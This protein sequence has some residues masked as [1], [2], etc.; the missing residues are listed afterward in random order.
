MA[1]FLRKEPCPRCRENGGDTTGDNLVIYNDDSAHCFVC[2]YTIHSEEHKALHAKEDLSYLENAVEFTQEWHEKFKKESTFKGGKY[3]G[4]RD[5]VYKHFG[6]RH[7]YNETTRVMESQWYPNTVEGEISG[8]KKRVLPKTFSAI[9]EV[10]GTA[11]LFGQWRFMN[12]KGKYVVITAGEID[13][14]SAY[15][16]LRDYQISKGNEDYEPIPVV[17]PTTGESGCIKQLQKH[18]EWLN[19]FDKIIV[20]FDNDKAGK[21]ATDKV[22]KVLPKGKVYVMDFAMKDT[23]EMLVAGKEKEWIN[24]FFKAHQYSPAGVIGSDRLYDEL[25]AKAA[26]PKITFPPF[27]KELN[28]ATAGGMSLKQIINVLAGSGIGKTT[29]VNALVKHWIFN[30]PYKVG[31]VSLEADC[32]EYASYLISESIGRKLSLIEDP[33]E[34]KSVLLSEDVRENAES[35]FQHED[36]SPRFYLIDDRGDFGGL[37]DRIEEL[38]ISCNVQL[39]VLDPL[40]DAMAGMAIDEQ[41]LFMSWMKQMIKMYDITFVNINHTRKGASGNEASKGA[42]LTEESIIGSST[43]YKSAHMNITLTRNKHE[44]DEI[45]RN[46]TKITLTKCRTT[47]ITGPVG[48]IYYESKTHRLWDK[49]EWLMQQNNKF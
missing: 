22:V 38:V 27:L 26:M 7:L 20:C 9:G 15:Q 28:K 1:T 3:R 10:G 33:E 42:E 48:E 49:Q 32:G 17:S 39:I 11:D 16:M 30:S 23:N 2:R 24:A 4:I 14:L 40:S 31:V 34:L 35:L 25:L 12:S 44:E 43:I 6:V 29:L 8:Y 36:G 41:E 45:L 5:D 18:Y 47:G 37:R 21:E 19:R 13:Q 46:T